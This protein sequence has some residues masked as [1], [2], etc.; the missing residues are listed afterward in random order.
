MARYTEWY[1][2]GGYVQDAGNLPR[3]DPNELGWD[4]FFTFN[5]SAD[6]TAHLT[7]TF[8]Y[9]AAP[10]RDLSFSLEPLR[11]HLFWLHHPRYREYTGGINNPYGVR[12]VSECDGADDRSSHAPVPVFPH[13]TR[14]EYES[15]DEHC[16]TAMFGVPFYEGPLT[17]ETDWYLAEGF[18]QEIRSHPTLATEWLS[19]LNP[20]AEDSTLT[21]T[22][23][24]PDGARR[25]E[26]EVKAERVLTVRVEELPFMPKSAEYAVRVQSRLPVVVQQTRRYFEQR[27]VPS[28]RST[29]ATMAC[30]WRPSR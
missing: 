13:W 14:A 5:P 25:H 20:N 19:V 26:A 17:D 22:F 15:W 10:P 28:T 27:G 6:G 12:L 7:A 1:Y 16:P 9:E 8:F 29:C 24:L 18:V 4:L 30:P 11:R 21:I 23:T 3:E 2:P